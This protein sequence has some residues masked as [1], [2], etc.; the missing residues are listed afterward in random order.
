MFFTYKVEQRENPA[1]RTVLVMSD[2]L[3][4]LKA[5]DDTWRGKGPQYRKRAGGACM[6][7]INTIRARLNRVVFM[8]VPSH[9]GVMPNAYA[10]AIAKAHTYNTHRQRTTRVLAR[11]IT[12]RSVIYEHE[13]TNGTPEL[14]DTPVFGATKRDCQG[15]I[16]ETKFRLGPRTRHTNLNG[17]IM[18]QISKGPP[19]DTGNG[20]DIQE[21]ARLQC[22]HARITFG[23]RNG[24]IAGGPQ[25]VARMCRAAKTKGPFSE[26][27]MMGGTS[28]VGA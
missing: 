28:P 2:C 5:I 26:R 15:W 16:R 11:N 27:A 6:E 9:V 25:G 22:A 4:A 23:L 1:Q 13:G 14:D 18:K 20:G 17:N 19:I 10:D 3:N 12:S 7:A 24:E 8:W 21:Q